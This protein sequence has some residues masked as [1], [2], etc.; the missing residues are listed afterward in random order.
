MPRVSRHNLDLYPSTSLPLSTLLLGICLISHFKK[1][2]RTFTMA[3][4]PVTLSP[5]IVTGG[6][7]FTGSHLVQGLLHHEEGVQIHVIAR[8]VRDEIPGVVY[9]QCDISSFHEVQVSHSRTYYSAASTGSESQPSRSS[10]VPT[11][12]VES[13]LSI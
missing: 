1:K 3:K 13:V 5:V 4:S 7:G 11:D 8:N 12:I 6:C 2:H 10:I 9:H